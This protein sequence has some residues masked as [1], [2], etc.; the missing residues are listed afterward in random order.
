M[1]IKESYGHFIN[2]TFQDPQSGKYIE[3]INP[4]D[5]SVVAKI[6]NGNKEDVLIAIQTAKQAAKMWSTMRALERGKIIVTVAKALRDNMEEL[7]E[8]ESAEMGMPKAFVRG[9]LIT[10]AN[11][12]DYYGGLAPSIEG[13]T[14]P[15]GE[16]THG[17]TLYEPYGVVGVITPWNAPL[18]QTT[19]SLG[20]AMAVGNTIVHKP[21]EHTSLTALRLAELAVEAGLPA[22]VWNVVTGYGAD[23][24]A[25][26]VEHL[27]IG[28]VSFTGSVTT[29]QVIAKI[30]AE[31]VMPVTLELGGKSPNIIFEDAD[32]EKTVPG[33][34]TGFVGNS[35]QICSAGT[36]ILVHKSIY[37][38]FTKLM[39]DAAASI[40]IGI[41]NDQPNIG[42]L[43]NKDQFQ[44]VKAYYDL[45]KEEGAIA[46][47]GGEAVEGKG[48]YVQPT[49]YTNVD[50]SMRIA[51]EEIFGPVGVFIPFE[52]EEEAIEIANQTDYGLAAGIWSQDISRVHRVAAK[53]KAG[54][55]YVNSYFDSGV[56]APFGGYKKS[57]LGRE[58]GQIAMKNYLQVKSVIVKL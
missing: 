55:I 9:S 31:K 33:V 19:R 4:H 52:T 41:E 47:T 20:P 58:K 46:L 17:Y 49:V 36:R 27:D 35:G 34:L 11:Y 38:K 12:L 51:N 23:A 8:L 26:I 14:L 22:G 56:E 18:N 28:K 13:A 1:N 42:P 48:Y 3:S 30:A 16:G 21:S 53:I 54:Q 40:K 50:M 25:P 57:G 15:M 37:D 10:A 32:L 2:G 6:A 5:E 7:I 45:A 24:G 29:G 44:K 39:A 43:A